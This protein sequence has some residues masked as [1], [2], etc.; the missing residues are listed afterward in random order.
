MP[1]SSICN[2]DN[3]LVLLTALSM[4]MKVMDVCERNDKGRARFVCGLASTEKHFDSF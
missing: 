3:G 2:V 4:A 1:F